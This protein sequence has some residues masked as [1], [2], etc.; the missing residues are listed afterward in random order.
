[1]A[2]SASFRA[3][4]HFSSHQWPYNF[5]DWIQSRGDGVFATHKFFMGTIPTSGGKHSA[6]DVFA[7]WFND[8]DGPPAWTM[9]KSCNS[10][11]RMFAG[12]S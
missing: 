4:I 9:Y 3:E 12:R 5:A 11:I 10:I 6:E 1:M 2:G 7:V 8:N